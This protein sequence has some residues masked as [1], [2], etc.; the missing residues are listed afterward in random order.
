LH[1]VLAVLGMHVHCKLHRRQLLEFCIS[2]TSH[3]IL[4]LKFTGVFTTIC[5]PCTTACLIHGATCCTSSQKLSIFP[6]LS[7]VMA[8]GVL[9]DGHTSLACSSSPITTPLTAPLSSTPLTAP[10]CG[11]PPERPSGRHQADWGHHSSPCLSL[12]GDCPL[13]FFLPWCFVCKRTTCQPTCSVIM[14]LSEPELRCK[15]H[16]TTKL[17]CCCHSLPNLS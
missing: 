17:L 15:W 3:T 12:T 16:V 9:A 5:L 13:Y 2:S 1:R 6:D 8:Q 7:L 11:P 14:F 10:S 4:G